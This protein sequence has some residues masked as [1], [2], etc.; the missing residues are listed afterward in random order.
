MALKVKKLSVKEYG[1]KMKAAIQ[2]SGKL[3][4][5]ESTAN[6]LHLDKDTHFSLYQDETN[7]CIMYMVANNN[8]PDAFPV[9]RSGIYYYMPTKVMFDMLE[10][11]YVHNTYIF[12]IIRMAKY[13]AELGGIVYQM[14]RRQCEKAE[15]ESM[16]EPAG[17]SAE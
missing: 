2:S 7:P 6:N 11:D 17:E 9:R 3:S 12:D 15:T 13:D 10:V 16:P 14:N 4:F 1:I 8:D 5:T